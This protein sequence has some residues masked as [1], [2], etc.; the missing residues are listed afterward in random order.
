[1][2]GFNICKIVIF[3]LFMNFK[4]EW[5]EIVSLSEGHEFQLWK[6]YRLFWLLS[7]VI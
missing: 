1:M 2:S 6:G 3:L 7:P 5:L 4:P